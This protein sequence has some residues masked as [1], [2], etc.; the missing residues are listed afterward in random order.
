M[1]IIYVNNTLPLALAVHKISRHF[2][3]TYG[4]TRKIY[5]I[6]S[7]NRN[8][9]ARRKDEIVRLSYQKYYAICSK[10]AGKYFSYQLTLFKAFLTL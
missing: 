2:W 7:A 9:T 4:E 6:L 5:S 1:Y 10:T 8:I 3:V